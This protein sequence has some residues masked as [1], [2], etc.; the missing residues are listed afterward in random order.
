MFN[1][2]RKQ[3]DIFTSKETINEYNEVIQT[4]EKSGT[5]EVFIS[6][7]TRANYESNGFN[8]LQCEY[9]GTST[10]PNFQKGMRIGTDYL[11]EYV[12]PHRNEYFLFLKEI[13]SN[14]RCK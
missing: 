5:A 14:G 11:V 12:V 9:A 1:N 3:Y 4:W 2:Q 13:E 8:I 6:L 7:N 10:Y